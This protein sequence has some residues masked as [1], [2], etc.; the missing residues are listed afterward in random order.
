MS[1][2]AQRV[3]RQAVVAPSDTVDHAAASRLAEPLAEAVRR[4]PVVFIVEL[5]GLLET[6]VR[7]IRRQ[8][9][10]GTF[11]IP[12]APAVDKRYRW[13]R[14]RVYR[15]IADTTLDSHRRSLVG[16]RSVPQR[17]IAGEAARERGGR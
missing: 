7:T 5:A 14:E 17:K 8:L 3:E 15:A 1:G 9:R 11:F 16:P 2:H 10:A 6:S 12:L 13:S 4:Q